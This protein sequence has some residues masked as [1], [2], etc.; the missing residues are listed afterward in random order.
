M[1]FA[2]VTD[3]W[4]PQVNGVVR[5]LSTMVKIGRAK[6]HDVLVIQPQDYPTFPLPNY[7]EIRLA[8]T[9]WK[10]MKPLREFSP[11]AVHIATEGTLGIFARI[12][13]NHLKIPFTTSYHTR[14]P[15]YVQERLPI[16]LSWGYR[17]LKWFH[18]AAERVMVP[19]PTMG[20]LLNHHGVHQKT[21]IW[22]RGVNHDL[23]RPRS[24]EDSYGPRPYW[25]CAGRVAVEK[26]IEAFLKLDLPGTKIIA[27]DGPARASMQ[28]KYPDA[29]WLGYKF[30][31]ELAKIYADS[32]VFVFPSKTDTF[33]NVLLES[34]ASGTPVAAFPV[35]GPQDVLK[36]GV[37]GV[38]SE[39]LKDA[40]LS[41]LR[42]DRNVV[43]RSSKDWD[44]DTCFQTFL[45]HLAPIDSGKF[46]Y[47]FNKF[48][49]PTI[50]PTSD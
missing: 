26:N 21:V 49:S 48:E 32:D 29:F 20:Q 39:N 19:T 12:W 7:P 17:F 37:D 38:L 8:T 24:Q 43:H 27:G 2:L 23:F 44:W 46:G 18:G 1:R 4:H 45:S 42:L 34:I 41:A 6:N 30:G 5:S 11:D 16:P 9:P 50:L 35:P 3:A 13:L 28:T 22:N 14:F 40:C 47:Q 36:P 10:M 31:E 15:E 33:G 25:L